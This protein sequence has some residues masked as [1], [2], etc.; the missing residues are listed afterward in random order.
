MVF[1]WEGIESIVVG[2]YICVVDVVI[3]D[4]CYCIVGCFLL[5]FIGS[6]IE[7]WKVIFM[8]IK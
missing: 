4:I 8:C 6:L 1:F 2:I 5:C 3:D 7:F